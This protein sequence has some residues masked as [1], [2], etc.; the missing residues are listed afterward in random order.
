MAQIS[1]SVKSDNLY[2]GFRQP[3]PEARPRIWWRWMGTQI[4]K[5]GITRDLEALKNVG[6]GGVIWFQIG[7]NVDDS[8]LLNN[9]NTTLPKVKPLTKEWWQLIQFAVKESERLGL[10]FSI[11]NCMGFSTSG[12]PWITPEQSMQKLIWSES[13]TEG[14]RQVKMQLPQPM[15]DK[16]WDYYKDIA[17]IAVKG[18]NDGSP[19]PLS[20]VRNISKSLNSAGE[21]NWQA[22]AGTWT[23]FRYGHTTTGVMQHPVAAEVNGLECDKMDREAMKTHFDN[24]SGRILKESGSLAGKTATSVFLDSYEAGAQTWTPKFREKFMEKRGYD[25]LPW[26]PVL[27]NNDLRKSGFSTLGWIPSQGKIIVESKEKTKRF[28]F[29]LE[30]T[31]EDLYIGENCVALKNL[32]G[33][34]PSVK[35]E[36]Q[37]YNSTYNFV[38]GGT[39]A[40]FVGCEFWHGNKVYGWWTI[41]LA[42]SASHVKGQPVVPAE[43]FTAEPQRGKW[44]VTPADMKAEGDLAF[45]KGANAFEVHVMAHQPWNEN[46]KPGVMAGP[47][48]VHLTRHNTWWNQSK[49]WIS[50]LT[51]AQ[52][53]LRQGLFVGDV[54]YLYPRWQKE[55][56]VPDGYRGDVID[57]NSI[58]QLMQVENGDLVL[59][60]GMRYKI[61]VL[62]PGHKMTPALAQKIKQLVAD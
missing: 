28:R 43:A 14:N 5:E 41:A 22:P 35:F 55:F 33:Q 53:M 58:I 51:R 60:G 31:I 10:T 12:G 46:V 54:C 8:A 9:P 49:E 52:Y 56:T 44:D 7:P 23:I 30:Q 36:L 4:S 42:A 29:D 1:P 48:G 21:L 24:Y 18:G 15:V 47:W 3:P 62:A 25:P 16:K 45:A 57:E 20:D 39:K 59:P 50:Y 37:P 19:V 34:F 32:V 40:D 6:I 27:G 17:V 2:S 11:Q 26:L 38:A 61:L 13:S